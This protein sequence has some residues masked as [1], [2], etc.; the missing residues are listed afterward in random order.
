M[1]EVAIACIS[2][3]NL[4][5][6]ELGTYGRDAEMVAVLTSVAPMLI[7]SWYCNI[8]MFRYCSLDKGFRID[9]SRRGGNNR[10]FTIFVWL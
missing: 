5:D 10:Y 8:L 7:G 6:L 3:R 1:K 9:P 4:S 2:P